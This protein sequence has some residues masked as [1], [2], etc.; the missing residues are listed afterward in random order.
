[1]TSAKPNEGVSLSM[2]TENE[3]EFAH[4]KRKEVGVILQPLSSCSTDEI[5]SYLSSP[6]IGSQAKPEIVNYNNDFDFDNFACYNDYYDDYYGDLNDDYTSLY[7]GVFMTNNETDE[8]RAARLADE[9]RTSWGLREQ[10]VHSPAVGNRGPRVD[11]E[12]QK[13]SHG[14]VDLR[15]ALNARRR[16]RHGRGHHHSTECIDGNDEGVTAFTRDLR[17]VNW[18]ASFKPTGIEK[19]DGKTNPES[20][21][22]VYTL[23]IRARNWLAGLLRGTIGSRGELRDHFI[24]NFE[25]TFERPSTH[26]ELYNVI[27]K[28]NE[29]IRDY[30]R[31]FSEKRNKISNMTDGNIIT[32]F[33]KGVR[34]EL[35][36]GKFGRKPPRTVKEMFEKANEYAK[37]DDAVL[38]SKQ[39]GSG[40]KPKKDSGNNGASSSNTHHKDRKCKPEDLKKDDTEPA[41][42]TLQD[43]RKELNHIFGGP[44]AYESK[45]KQKLTDREINAVQPEVPQFLQ[46]GPPGAVPPVLD[47]VV[48]NVKLK[49][50]LI[51]GGRALNILFAKTLDEMQI[52]RIELRL[53]NAPFHGV[54]LVFSSTPLGQITMPV[55]FGT[56]ENFHTDNVCFEVAD[57]ETA[58]H[59]MLGRPALAKFMA[60]PHYT[61]MMMKM[62]R[63][64]GVISLRSDVKQA[65]T[66]DKESCEMAQSC[67]QALGREEVCLATSTSPEG[68]VP[69]KNLS[70]SRENDAKTKKIPLDP[71]DPSKTTVIGVELD[72]K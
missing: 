33:T 49:R 39:S 43:S 41:Q 50:T 60:I 36:I 45:R 22:I 42:G 64:R 61:Y 26:F 2:R 71:L 44:L 15:E 65:I 21:L 47:P 25:G 19:Y 29:P 24:A 62:P 31:R 12:Q 34:N 53:R 28:P 51:D 66:C 40:W 17:R 7:F 37:A 35:L 57:F 67:E 13:S 1:M 10:L 56:G 52:S 6:N 46:C 55:T 54:F 18:P 3:S 14:L 5:A 20:W 23:A 4:G 30:I 32:A 27:Q 11:H 63:P 58:Y 38:A 9:E 72:C 70:K 68:D 16:A 8:Q 59:A 69:A 48:R